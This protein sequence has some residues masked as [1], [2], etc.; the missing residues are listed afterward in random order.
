MVVSWRYSSL[1]V[2]LIDMRLFFLYICR[3]DIKIYHGMDKEPVKALRQKYLELK[4]HREMMKR[5]DE[6]EKSLVSQMESEIRSL[7]TMIENKTKRIEEDEAKLE[8]F[9]NMLSHAQNALA[10]LSNNTKKLEGVIQNELE[11]LK[12]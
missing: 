8:K 11:A 5:E 4:R 6:K 10:Q 1:G 2:W 7:E 3:C 12:E 9:D